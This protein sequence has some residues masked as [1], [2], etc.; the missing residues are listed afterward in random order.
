MMLVIRQATQNGSSRAARRRGS[1]SNN[2]VVL[3]GFC[4]SS[5]ELLV[6]DGLDLHDWVEYNVR[7]EHDSL[8]E[9][10][11]QTNCKGTTSVLSST[12]EVVV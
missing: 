12:E 4:Q 2:V 1:D 11:E 10:Q 8:D 3:H 5:S 7:E 6:K 9:D